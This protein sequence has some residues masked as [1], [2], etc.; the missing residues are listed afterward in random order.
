[1]S[2]ST[3]IDFLYLSEKDVIEAGVLD[4]KKCIDCM[5]EVMA[6]LSAGDYRLGGE[7]A[8]SHGIFMSFPKESEIEGMPLDAPDRRFMAMPAYLGGRFHLAGQK[9]YGSNKENNKKGLP[10]SILMITLNDVDTGRPICYMSG[11]LISAMR[12]GAVPFVAARY[13]IKT[14][15]EVLGIIGAGVIGTASTICALAE[16]PSIKTIKIKAGSPASLSAKKLKT[17]IEKNYPSVEDVHICDTLEEAVRDTDIICEAVSAKSEDEHPFI[18]EKWLK[19]RCV[20]LSSMNLCF[21]DDF[22]INRADLVID[23]WRMYIPWLDEELKKQKKLGK[24]RPMGV[25]GMAFLNLVRQGKLKEED[26]PLIGDLVRGVYKPDESSDKP[27]V[28]GACGMPIED[29]GLGKEIYESAKSK[30]L[31]VELNLWDEPY[32]S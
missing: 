24:A 31:G 8:N 22:L 13:Y 4:G 9:W 1:M 26:V 14:A 32:L 16:Y 30:G 25:C 20:I 2:D 18:D 3:R 27:V 7:D 10:R 6:L 15:P 28:I 11:N 17:Y 23:N 12:T 29:V 5:S 21:D 19:P